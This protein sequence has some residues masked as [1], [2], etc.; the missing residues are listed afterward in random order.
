MCFYICSAHA[1]CLWRQRWILQSILTSLNV[2][3]VT[4]VPFDKAYLR[5]VPVTL[6]MFQAR[7]NRSRSMRKNKGKKNNIIWKQIRLS[8]MVP[9]YTDLI[10]ILVDKKGNWFA[11]KPTLKFTISHLS[12]NSCN[13]KRLKWNTLKHST[14]YTRVMECATSLCHGWI[15]P[16]Y[17][18]AN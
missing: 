2:L 14:I 4:V 12:F 18:N 13:L 3:R 16:L 6:S 11:V 15:I 10:S 17:W 7:P 8:K 9:W 1:H 5:K